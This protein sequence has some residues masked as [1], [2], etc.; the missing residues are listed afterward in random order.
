M[1]H[2]KCHSGPEPGPGQRRH[3]PHVAQLPGPRCRTGSVATAVALEKQH[4]LGQGGCGAVA[5]CRGTLGPPHRSPQPRWAPGTAGLR[6]GAVPSLEVAKSQAAEEGDETKPE[7]SVVKWSVHQGQGAAQRT[8]QS[9][10]QT[11]ALAVHAA[12]PHAGVCVWQGP[13]D[14][15]NQHLGEEQQT[16]LTGQDITKAR[17]GQPENS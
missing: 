12:L 8:R 15:E 13:Q 6:C 1:S 16:L 14:T 7:S 9:W 3:R 4:G 5:P 10:D 2:Q 17:R 11:S